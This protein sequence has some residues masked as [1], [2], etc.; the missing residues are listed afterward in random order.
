MARKAKPPIARTVEALRPHREEATRKN[1]PTAEYQSVLEK[2]ARDPVW[3]AH[4]G[5]PHSGTNA[6]RRAGKLSYPAP[7][8][9]HPEQV[10]RLWARGRIV[11]SMS[12]LLSFSARRT[13]SYRNLAA[14][15]SLGTA[16]FAESGPGCPN[17][18]SMPVLPPIHTPSFTHRFC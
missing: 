15:G 18:P 6:N 13:A 1:I 17:P 9:W 2:E 11:T 16:T 5:R 10:G 4:E 3:V 12:S 14:D 7:G 8:G